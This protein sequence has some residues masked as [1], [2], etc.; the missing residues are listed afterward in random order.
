MLPYPIDRLRT[1][2]R[3]LCPPEMPLLTRPLLWG[4]RLLYRHRHDD[5]RLGTKVLSNTL[6]SPFI[7]SNASSLN[8]WEIMPRAA[9]RSLRG[10]FRPPPLPNSSKIEGHTEY[11]W[12]CLDER[13]EREGF[14]KSVE[15]DR[16]WTSGCPG[17]LLALGGLKRRIR[18]GVGGVTR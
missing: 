12:G 13:E 1:I 16:V 18:K 14:L 15:A 10:W 5:A 3:T 7:T 6:Y 4:S 9:A 11:R 2:D 8:A 17:R